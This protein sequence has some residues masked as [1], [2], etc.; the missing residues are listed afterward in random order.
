MTSKLKIAGWVALGAL[1]GGLTTTQFGATARNSVAPLPLE[2]MQQLA[3]VFGMIKTDYVES[4]DE[5]KL[6]SDAIGGMVSGLDPHSV[7]FDKT[8]SRNSV[9]ARLANSSAW[10][11]K[12]AWKTVWSR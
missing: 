6:I 7:Y 10:A 5:K 4:V 8:L 12:S 2:E 1:A 11:S 9:R 3:A